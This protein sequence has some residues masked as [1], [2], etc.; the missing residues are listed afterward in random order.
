MKGLIINEYTNKGVKNLDIRFDNLDTV[1][2]RTTDKSYR[3]GMFVEVETINQRQAI[4]CKV[5]KPDNYLDFYP[6][7]PISTEELKDAIMSFVVK[8][9][10]ENYLKLIEELIINNDEYFIYPAAK[11]IHHAYIG[12]IAA[13]T[14][15][16]LE[17]AE[18]FVNK[19]PTINSDLLYTGAIM[20]DYAKLREYESYGLTY[21]IEG[22]LLGHISMCNEEIANFAI[23]NNIN[24][25]LDM[26]ALKHLVLSHHGRMD[27]GSP[28]EPMLLEAYILSVIDE[29][30][31]KIDIIQNEL[32]KTEKNNLTSSIMAFDR[33]RFLNLEF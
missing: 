29:T 30:D 25:S 7:G 22:N 18:F 12:G 14:L 24:D 6:V 3:V 26:I 1:N 28:K 5:I 4:S 31:S 21:S 8:I 16:M 15:S 23:N 27:Y 19:Y 20:H 33:R 10:N 13:H 17:Y 11:S 32:A 2:V 9:K